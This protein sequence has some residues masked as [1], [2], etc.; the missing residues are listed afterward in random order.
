MFELNLYLTLKKHKGDTRRM[1]MNIKKNNLVSRLGTMFN[2]NENISKQQG[3]QKVGSSKTRS[4]P[5]CETNQC[6][7]FPT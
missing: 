4:I 7:G 3:H 2:F 5:H 6:H 1:L